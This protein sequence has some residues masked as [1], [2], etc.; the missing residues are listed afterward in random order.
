MGER[1]HIHGFEIGTRSTSVRA[2]SLACSAVSANAHDMH[3]YSVTLSKLSWAL[4]ILPFLNF[5]KVLFQAPSAK[6]K[7]ELI[8]NQ[9]AVG[10]V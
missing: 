4:A 7:L 5:V 8:I 10:V 3:R 2:A 1:Q 6:P 9:G